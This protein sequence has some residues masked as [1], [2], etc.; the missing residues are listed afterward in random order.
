MNL[1]PHCE[2]RDQFCFVSTLKHI[3]VMK[4]SVSFREFL[5]FKKIILEVVMTKNLL[6]ATALLALFGV[7]AAKADTVL[8][9]TITGTFDNPIAGGVVANNVPFI[10]TPTH[11]EAEA[12]SFTIT[13]PTS[14][15]SIEAFIATPSGVGSVNLGIMASAGGLPSGTFLDNV[16]VALT[17]LNNPAN[18]S[19]LNWT[20]GPGTYWLVATANAGGFD[21]WNDGATA[22]SFST[23]TSATG[24]NGWGSAGG[25]LPEAKITGVAVTPLPAALPLFASALAAI[26]GLFG[27]RKRRLAPA[28]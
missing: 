19:G 8:L 13:G 6:L 2:W 11:S 1:P 18:V 27:W 12:I 7:S 25:G 21:F 4:W 14:I 3:N 16:N 26:A 9:N 15:T 17:S 28:A 10:P 23:S 22:G 20:L 5:Q 24:G